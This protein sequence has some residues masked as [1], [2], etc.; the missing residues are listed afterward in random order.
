LRGAVGEEGFLQRSQGAVAVAQAF[1]RFDPTAFDLTHGDETGAGL[2]SVQKHRAGAAVAGVA[3]DLGAGE[4]E[5]VAPRR[6]QP[7]NRRTIPRR[8]LAV[9]DKTHPH[10]FTSRSKRRS[11]VTTASRR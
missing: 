8:R 2:P 9:Q 4:T 6:R 5:V 3:A 10:E 7:P 11:R 1:D